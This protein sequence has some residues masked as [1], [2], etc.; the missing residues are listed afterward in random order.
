[1]FQVFRDGVWLL[2][3]RTREM[4]R[5]LDDATAEEFAWAPD[6]RRIAYHSRRDGVWKIW[7]MSV[8]A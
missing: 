2:D 4:R 7:V 6:G 5:I 8:P 1:V 3:V